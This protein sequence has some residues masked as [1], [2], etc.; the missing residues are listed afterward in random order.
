MNLWKSPEALRKARS[1]ELAKAQF[2]TV[3]YTF[4]LTRLESA[5]VKR[6]LLA[7][8]GHDGTLK[9]RRAHVC[10]Q[11]QPDRLQGELILSES[12]QGITNVPSV[13]K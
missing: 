10:K 11:P 2:G 13:V 12:D 1:R 7:K 8:F 4:E 3:T 9:S 6:H 5:S